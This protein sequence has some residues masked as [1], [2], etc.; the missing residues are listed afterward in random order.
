MTLMFL[1]K[2]CILNKKNVFFI[3]FGITI[4]RPL[5]RLWFIVIKFYNNLMVLMNCQN[6][7]CS[8]TT[9]NRKLILIFKNLQK[10]LKVF[11]YS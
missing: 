4:T 6:V 1:N 8:K 7:M 2:T 9:S 10:V 3:V 11:V 5:N